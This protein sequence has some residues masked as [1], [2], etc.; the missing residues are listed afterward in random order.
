MKK[1]IKNYTIKQ[2]PGSIQIFEKFE[3]QESNFYLINCE[4]SIKEFSRLKTKKDIINIIN[5]E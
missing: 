1:T 2:Y 4:D 3:D 5:N